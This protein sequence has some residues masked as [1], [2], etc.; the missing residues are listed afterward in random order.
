MIPLP[1]L[2]AAVWYGVKKLATTK[3]V[4]LALAR[5]LLDS[6]KKHEKPAEEEK[7]EEL[8]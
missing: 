8:S 4:R 3:A 5:Y 2:G 7:S 1:G 6:V